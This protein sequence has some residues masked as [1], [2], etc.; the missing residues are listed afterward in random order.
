MN[1]ITREEV[2]EKTGIASRE[3]NQVLKRF[4]IRFVRRVVQYAERRCNGIYCVGSRSREVITEAQLDIAL[5]RLGK[6]YVK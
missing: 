4:G 3:L 5:R 6:K 2:A 1:Y